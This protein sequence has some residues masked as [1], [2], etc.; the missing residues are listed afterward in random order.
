[1]PGTEPGEPQLQRAAG[2]LA[3]ELSWPGIGGWGKHA[4]GLGNPQAGAPAAPSAG[5]RG[6]LWERPAL[7]AASVKM[8]ASALA[9]PAVPSGP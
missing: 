9:A 8:A 2:A 5:R 3:P 7:S 6:A 4:K 1:M